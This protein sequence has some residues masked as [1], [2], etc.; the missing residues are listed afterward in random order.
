MS[1]ITVLKNNMLC[2]V[3]NA[4]CT[5]ACAV[6]EASEE[7]RKAATEKA[8]RIIN[9]MTAFTILVCATMFIFPVFATS[10][11]AGVMTKM[12]DI[13]CMVFRYVGVIL[14]VYSVG[15]LVLSIKNEDSDSKSRATTMI[16]ISC[17]LIGIKTIVDGLDLAQYLTN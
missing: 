4:Y 12:I 5:A 11:A 16:V 17:I 8:R 9:V 10:E 6:T 3:G 7:S 2:A 15:Q 14:L 1:K 13:I